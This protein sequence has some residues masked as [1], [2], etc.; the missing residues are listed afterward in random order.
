MAVVHEHVHQRT[1][2]QKQPRQIRHHM[3]TMLG[4]EKESGNDGKQDKHLLDAPIDQ[5]MPK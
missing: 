3:R 5:I 1:R 2:S 4:E